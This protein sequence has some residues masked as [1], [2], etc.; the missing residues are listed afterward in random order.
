MKDDEAEAADDEGEGSAADLLV[1]LTPAIRP[2][3]FATVGADIF[4]TKT[5]NTINR[6]GIKL[7]NGNETNRTTSELQ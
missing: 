2:V 7:M 5:G 4:E 3:F 1:L 6:T